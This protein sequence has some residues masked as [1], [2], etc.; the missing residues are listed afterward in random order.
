MSLPRKNVGPP[1]LRDK[2]HRE[3]ALAHLWVSTLGAH[4]NSAEHFV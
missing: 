3:L 4:P 2:I 1:W